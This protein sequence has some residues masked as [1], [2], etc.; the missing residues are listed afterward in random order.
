[1][2]ILHTSDWHL[3]SV[4]GG[5]PRNPDLR[6]SFEQIQGYLE[7][8]D[9]D[10]MIVS[11]DLFRE[12]SRPEQAQVGISIIKEYFQSFI[13]RG[14]T[15]VAITGNHDSE[16]FFATLRDALELVSFV[17]DDGIQ[18]GGRL[19]VAPNARTLNLKDRAGELI[20]FVL[21]PYPTIRYLRGEQLRFQNIEERNQAIGASFNNILRTLQ[22]R[23]DPQWPAILVSHVL[24]RGVEATSGHYLDQV[25]EVILEPSDLSFPWS[26]V[27]LGHLH[28]PGEAIAGAP[29]IRHAGS[30]ER[31]D[32]GER[33][34]QKSVVFLEIKD[35][36][37]VD[38]PQ[39]LPL[40]STTFYEVEITNPETEIPY[41]A[42]QYPDAQKA[43]VR[44]ILHWDSSTQDRERYCQ[45]IEKIFPRWYTRTLK[46]KR[47]G[48]ITEASLTFHQV[49][50]VRGTTLHYLQNQ[51]TN[52]QDREELLRL[53]EELFVEEELV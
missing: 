52:N 48:A 36:R 37:L 8:R 12:R 46:D 33:D 42:E 38:T 49:H 41:L 35:R 7:A 11:G 19:Y 13:R 34:D 27:A 26:Y 45:Q 5:R 47:S 31:M 16:V 14:G 32:Y 20:Q 2:K 29:H 18:A 44:Y 24:V 6:R 4:L 25:N 51:L 28:Q 17:D 23:L 40:Q 3:N 39:L 50:D 1:M 53:A 22:G 43:L 30:I 10:V 21:M 9:V 15:I